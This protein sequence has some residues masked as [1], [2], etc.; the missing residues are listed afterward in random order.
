MIDPR[1]FQ[2]SRPLPL[3]LIAKQ[4][5]AEL[6]D[7]LATELMIVDRF[8]GQRRGAPVERFL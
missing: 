3:G 7:P 8:V 5:G 6:S 4:V 2:R 1:F